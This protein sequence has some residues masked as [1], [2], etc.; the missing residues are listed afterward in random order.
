MAS[1]FEDKW[2]PFHFIF[3]KSRGSFQVEARDTENFRDFPV[4]R[5]MLKKYTTT[6]QYGF[7]SRPFRLIIHNQ[8]IIRRNLTDKVQKCRYVSQQS[9]N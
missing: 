7:L 8:F 5:E 1:I 3:A 2:L 6:S 9:T 4:F